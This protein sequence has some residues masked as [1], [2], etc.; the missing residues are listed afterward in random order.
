MIPAIASL[1]FVGSSR[2][3]VAPFGAAWVESDADAVAIQL[4]DGG[5]SEEEAAPHVPEA[6]SLPAGT[7]VVVLPE[8]ARGKGLLSAFS[9]KPIARAVRAGALLLRG[10]VEIGAELD[11]KSKMDLVFGRSP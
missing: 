11:P 10:Y 4:R 7:W 9:R 8:A 1:R 6:S 3:R 2:P 5:E